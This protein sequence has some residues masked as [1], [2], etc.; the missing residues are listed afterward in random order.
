[1]RRKF[2]LDDKIQL[3]GYSVNGD[4]FRVGETL[5]LDAYWYAA[6]LT[7][8]NF[9]SFLHFSSSEGGPPVAQVD[10]LHPADIPTSLW[11]PTGYI[12][13]NYELQLPADLP[14][15]EYQ[16]SI[17]LYTCELAPVDDCGNGYRPTV[18]NDLGE[19]IGDS[20]V[21]ATIRVEAP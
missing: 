20:I 3:L 6:E 13:D 5:V 12:L 2:T 7:E 1:M 15:G 11:V 10:K 4:S 9:H 8:T 19:V 17:G 14:R 18:K 21:I 16:L